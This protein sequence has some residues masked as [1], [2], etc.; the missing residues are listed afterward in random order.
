MWKPSRRRILWIAFAGV[1][2]IGGAL[3][4]NWYDRREMISALLE[5]GRLDPIPVSATDFSITTEGNMFTRGF[6]AHFTAPQEQ[7]DRWLKSSPGTNSAQVEIRG[8]LQ[9]YHIQP[10]GGAG[11]AEVKVDVVNHRVAIHVYW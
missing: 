5:W 6:R 1:V 2:L 11:F 4:Y 8:P 3:L 7:I 9:T 10:G